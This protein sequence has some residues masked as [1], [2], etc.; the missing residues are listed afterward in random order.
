MN[1]RV[2][3]SVPDDRHLDDRRRSLK[4]AMVSAVAGLGFEVVG[5]EPEQ[6]G[7]GLAAHPNEWTVAR[8]QALLQRCDGVL[9]LALARMHVHVVRPEGD[10]PMAGSPGSR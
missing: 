9:V 5:F 10:L 6:F 8:A 7:T 3:V 2:F 4:R 1:P